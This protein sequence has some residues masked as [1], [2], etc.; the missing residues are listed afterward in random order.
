MESRKRFQHTHQ[1]SSMFQIHTQCPNTY[2]EP[3]HNSSWSDWPTKCKMENQPHQ[4]TLWQNW[5]WSNSE[6]RTP[7][8]L[9]QC[10]FWQTYLAI[11]P[12]WWL[13]GKKKPMKSSPTLTII[14][15]LTLT[16]ILPFG[17]NFGK[18]YSLIKSSTLHG[19]SC[20]MHSQ[21]KTSSTKEDYTE[22]CPAYCVTIPMK[23]KIIS[24]YTVI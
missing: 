16:S 23:P 6:H 5:Q 14:Q 9:G 20:I 7:Y 13:S 15:V 10:Y 17:N 2:S 11:F 8:S 12:Q 19:K 4:S 21:S 3:N 1:S 18:S 24:S 22:L